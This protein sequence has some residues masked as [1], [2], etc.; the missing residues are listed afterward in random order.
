MFVVGTLPLAKLRCFAFVCERGRTVPRGRL[1]GHF[2]ESDDPV[3]QIAGELYAIA[4]G[5]YV[6]DA[7]YSVEEEDGGGTCSPLEDATDR[8]EEL[9]ES[10]PKTYQHWRRVAETLMEVA[11]IGLDDSL[12][13]VALKEDWG[14]DISGVEIVQYRKILKGVVYELEGYLA[15]E[16]L[17]RLARVIGL[18]SAQSV[19]LFAQRDF[20]ETTNAALR[21]DLL[22]E[23]K[24]SRVWQFIRRA[25]Q[26]S[27]ATDFPTDDEIVDR[28]P[29]RYGRTVAGR[30]VGPAYCA[31]VRCQEVLLLADEVMK[32][33]AYALVA[34]GYPLAAIHE[35][36][37]LL[38]IPEVD[39]TP[40]MLQQLARLAMDAEQKLLGRFAARCQCDPT[41][42]W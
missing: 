9:R 42:R 4:T 16:T 18:T 39:A 13:N 30:V 11:P 34:A 22:H 14:L 19:D 33:I 12:M 32:S 41:H 2:L 36:Q 25:R 10:D 8:F 15:E 5:Q 31:D 27:S 29:K 24:R 21:N 40:D 23:E 38:E 26:A 1:A 20:I 7:N 37:F 17:S 35:H 3:G 6:P 28:V